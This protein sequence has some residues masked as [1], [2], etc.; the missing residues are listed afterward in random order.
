MEA[1]EAEVEKAREKAD[2]EAREAEV[3][4]SDAAAVSVVLQAVREFSK[5]FAPLRVLPD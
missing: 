3:T 4:V 5:P 2:D 1:Y